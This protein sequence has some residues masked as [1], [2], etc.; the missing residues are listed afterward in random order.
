MTVYNMKRTMNILGFDKLMEKLNAW[1]PKYKKGWLYAQKM[2][3]R[4][5]VIR[6]L[7]FEQKMA[8]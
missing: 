3:K 7:F 8:A 1:K 2:N 5:A 4:E 6:T